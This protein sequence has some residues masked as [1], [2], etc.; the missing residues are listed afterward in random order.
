MLAGQMIYMRQAMT[1]TIDSVGSGGGGGGTAELE[2]IIVLM[3][4][5]IFRDNF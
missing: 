4:V 5:D 2:F 1:S 3:S